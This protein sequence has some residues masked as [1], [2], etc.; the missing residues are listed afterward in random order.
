MQF[1][2]D[3]SDSINIIGAFGTEGIRVGDGLVVPPS[4]I[5][6]SVI[7][8]NWAVTCVM[9]LSADQ[10][11]PIIELEPELIVLGSGSHLT[12]PSPEIGKMVNQRG[13]GFEVMDT[14][15]GCRTYNVLAH[16]GRKVALALLPE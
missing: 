4:V 5:A 8:E 2:R 10:M 15:A 7:I 6:V 13:I 16:E 14:A 12:F 11:M 3:T 1:H 9:E